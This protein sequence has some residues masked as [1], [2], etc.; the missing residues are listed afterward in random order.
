MARPVRAQTVRPELPAPRLPPRLP[1]AVQRSAANQTPSAPLPVI[2][3]AN[4]M[5]PFYSYAES[6][7]QYGLDTERVAPLP[8]SS[9]RPSWEELLVKA[10]QRFAAPICGGI[11][12]LIFVVGYLAYSS[13]SRAA[14]ASSA[15]QVAPIVMPAEIAMTAPVEDEA[16]VVSPAAVAEPT[17]AE[18]HIAKPAKAKRPAKRVASSSKR[19]PVHLN[20]ATPLGDLR[21][22]RSR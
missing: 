13:Q 2:V 4:A 19:R 11:A 9:L 5:L 15:T 16:P 6:Q 20:D 10:W 14:I 21:P 7:P 18:V 8:M 17:V 22:S 1:P 3:P 12:G